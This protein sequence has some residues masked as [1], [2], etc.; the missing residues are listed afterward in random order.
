MIGQEN[1]RKK[2]TTI[3]DNDK[4]S[5]FII[6]EG[7]VGSG[8]K[9]LANV[10]IHKL[11]QKG[12]IDYRVPDVKIDTIRSMIQDA[13]TTKSDMVVLIPDAEKMSLAAKNS[14]LKIVEE[15]PNNIY[16]ILTTIDS[17]MLMST[18]RSRA[19]I[20]RMEGYSSEEL[21]SYAQQFNTKSTDEELEVL[22]N[23]CKTPGDIQLFFEYKG[24]EFV[25]VV[26]KVVDNISNAPL[27]NAMK[28]AE[29]ISMKDGAEG[30]DLAFFWEVFVYKCF[31]KAFNQKP[32][33]NKYTIYMRTTLNA[34]R[35]LSITGINKQ[36][37]FDKWLIELQEVE[38]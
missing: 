34:L 8:K 35:D 19:S 2:L 27:F 6:I 12:F 9:T 33:F 23:I 29:N 20:Y 4:L 25:E 26:D 24:L 18:I 1:L 38:E 22:K 13:Y 5:R 37:L 28:I 16:F 10:I 7:E 31:Q 3:I 21:K 15:P 11:Q 30:Y 32:L 14:L 36:M 17:N